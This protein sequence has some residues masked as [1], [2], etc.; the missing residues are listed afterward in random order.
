MTDQNTV[1]AIAA[2]VATLIAIRG[3]TGSHLAEI[4][5]V[6][7]PTISR[8]INGQRIADADVLK[9]IA[10]ALNTSMDYLTENHENVELSA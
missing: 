9:K 3:W 10:K 5:G 6:S 4:T 8:I 1:N 7:Q 2:N